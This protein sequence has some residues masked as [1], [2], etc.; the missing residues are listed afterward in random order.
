M[1]KLSKCMCKI[2]MIFIS[3]MSFMVFSSCGLLSAM[4]ST[5][6]TSNGGT[7]NSSVDKT[8]ETAREFYDVVVES[9]KCLDSLADDIYTCW[10]G[11]IYKGEYDGDIDTAILYAQY[12][13]TNN[14][15]KIKSN[16]T[17]IY[18]LYKEVRDSSLSTELKAVMSA[19]SDYYELVVNV[20]GSFN[21]YSASMETMKKALA[22][23]LRDLAFEL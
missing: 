1:K 22:S 3:V 12:I 11:A 17:V 16:E 7:N 21:S 23:A 19:Y 8:I 20:S 13:N 4:L 5:S 10:H 14:L 2:G 6:S 15:K 9:Q 18:N